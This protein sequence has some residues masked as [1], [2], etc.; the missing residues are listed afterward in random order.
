M[1][2]GVVQRMRR[3][4]HSR[5]P[6]FVAIQAV[7]IACLA[8]YLI[9]PPVALVPTGLEEIPSVKAFRELE[10]FLQKH[11]LRLDS[12][13]GIA[14]IVAEALPPDHALKDRLFQ[15]ELAYTRSMTSSR[16]NL[17]AMIRFLKA[18]PDADVRRHACAHFERWQGSRKSGPPE[19][20][21]PRMTSFL[22]RELEDSNNDGWIRDLLASALYNIQSCLPMEQ[23]SIEGFR[24]ILAKEA[25]P[26]LNLYTPAPG[27]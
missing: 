14:G 5:L 27:C 19:G 26:V 20:W 2:P 15:L 21:D 8:A 17:E 12:G 25:E 10:W 13:P 4:H 11:R 23:N 24:R 16:E 1:I 7:L 18:Q 3:P 9:E 22:L 6:Y